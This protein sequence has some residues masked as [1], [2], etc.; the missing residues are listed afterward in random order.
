[1]DSYQNNRIQ[2][3]E[4]KYFKRVRRATKKDRIRKDRPYKKGLESAADTEE[5]GVQTT[6]LVVSQGT[7]DNRQT[8]RMWEVTIR[9]K[10]I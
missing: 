9:I 1:M 2:I 6:E 8:K 10:R 3:A 7:N 4:M 5:Y